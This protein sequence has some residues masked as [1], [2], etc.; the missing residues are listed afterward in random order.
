MEAY[1]INKIITIQ[2]IFRGCACRKALTSTDKEF[3]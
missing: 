1:L 3:K 2:R